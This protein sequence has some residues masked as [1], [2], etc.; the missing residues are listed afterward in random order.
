M[1]LVAFFL[2]LIC[3][4]QSFAEY[5]SRLGLPEGAIARLGKGEIRDIAYSPDGSRLAVA[6]S[7][8]IWVYDVSSG[9]ELA[10]LTGHTPRGQ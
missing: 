10:L 8:G 5:Y 4:S 1:F 3:V 7:L 2:M 9:E 6:G